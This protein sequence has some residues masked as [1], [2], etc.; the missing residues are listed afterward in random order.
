ML[1]IVFYSK[2][3]SRLSFVFF[4][5][6]NSVIQSSVK[7]SFVYLTSLPIPHF[8]HYLIPIGTNTNLLSRFLQHKPFWNEGK[9]R[10]DQLEIF[11]RLS[12]K[13][14]LNSDLVSHSVASWDKYLLLIT[15]THTHRRD[16]YKLNLVFYNVTNI[17]EGHFIKTHAQKWK[18]I[19]HWDR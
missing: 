11:P 18:T 17:K 7:K 19:W 1:P 5:T 9:C 8:R 12:R 2:F 4:F 3:W 15:H 10:S 13:T 16:Q 14:T 6:I